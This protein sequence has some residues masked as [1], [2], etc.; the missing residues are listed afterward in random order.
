MFG[1]PMKHIALSLAA[2][3]TLIACTAEDAGTES[4]PA[5][6]AGC[7][8]DNGGITLPDG[9]CASVFAEVGPARH[10]VVAPNG[11]VFVAL[12]DQ[13]GGVRGGVVALRDSDGDGRAD[14]EERWGDGG[15]NG[16]LLYGGYLYFAPNDA[17]LRYPLTEGA[18]TPSGP[19]E[20]VVSGLP[21]GGNH[22]AKS[23]AIGEDGALYVNIGGPTNA[24]QAAARQPGSPGLDPCPQLERRG[25][26]WRFDAN[27]T[28]Q[29]QDDG[30]RF[31][32]GLRNTVALNINPATGTAFGVIHG[33]DSLHELWPEFYTEAQRVEKPS[34]EFVAIV[35]G[36]D[37][38]WPYC[39]HDPETNT[40]YLGPEYGGNG[41]RIGRCAD[42]KAPLIGFP[43]HWAPDDLE[44]YSGTQF[45]ASYRGGAFIAFHG[46]WNRAP[47]PQ[48]GYRVV[49]V[50]MDGD[51]VAGEW[52]TFAD[53]FGGAEPGPQS[54]PYRP[55][56]IAQGPDGSLYFSDTR[57]GR[58]WKVTYQGK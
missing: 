25:G 6:Q 3:A 28:G 24:C 13:R 27:R 23:L 16:I 42:K 58:I 55:V 31:A 30:I 39:Y 35:E 15:G 12:S 46:S 21:S 20:T 34:E 2:L 1:R 51:R 54:A 9:F 18:M 44:F 49:F 37:F 47:A 56:G 36:D 50:P 45:P 38:G 43:A 29:T 52:Q 41:I 53:G 7:D 33:R 4:V 5:Q 19:V 40:K 17:V 57:E 10:L 11:D 22:A 26:I 48:A 8:P 32:T 14:V